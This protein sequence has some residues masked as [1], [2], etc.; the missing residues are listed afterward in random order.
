MKAA[1]LGTQ[2]N[3]AHD[4]QAL[5]RSMG[6][7]ALQ[8]MAGY[9]PTRIP[10]HTIRLFPVETPYR[11]YALDMVQLCEQPIE[12]C[13]RVP[14]LFHG[15]SGADTDYRATQYVDDDRIVRSVAAALLNIACGE[16]P[17]VKSWKPS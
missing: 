15:C 8:H 10:P 9:M 13:N 11:D 7:S 5:L 6:V 14:Y 4:E 3:A 1:I 16:A 2:H 17:T 12:V